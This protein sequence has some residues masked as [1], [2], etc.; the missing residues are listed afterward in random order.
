MRWVTA[1]ATA[2]TGAHMHVGMCGSNGAPGATVDPAAVTNFIGVGQSAGSANLKRYYGGSAV[3]TALDLGANFPIGTAL[4]PQIYELIM[5]APPNANNL[6]AMRVERVNTG[7]VYNEL[8]TAAT[9]GTQL[10]DPT[11]FLG[12]R[13]IRSNNATASAVSMDIAMFYCESNL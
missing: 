12:P 4:A 3:R 13:M 11:T 5:Y 6:L 8:I 1:D 7:D 10:P 9:P 2:V